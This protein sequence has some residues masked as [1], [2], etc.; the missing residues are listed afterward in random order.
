MIVLSEV[1]MQP[2]CQPRT[3]Q[4]TVSFCLNHSSNDKKKF[5]QRKFPWEAWSRKISVKEG[6][7][8]EQLG[9]WS[10]TE[11]KV[12]VMHWTTIHEIWPSWLYNSGPWF[13]NPSAWLV[14][15]V[16]VKHGSQII[17]H[18]LT[19]CNLHELSNFIISL[20]V[21]SFRDGIY[22]LWGGVGQ[23]LMD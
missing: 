8:I 7:F 20:D 5:W 6:S 13:V 21:I 4:K 18:S 11:E 15:I 1:N 9:Q 10:W 3:H 14:K 19:V 16:E 22:H 2:P 12:H 17:R 23:R